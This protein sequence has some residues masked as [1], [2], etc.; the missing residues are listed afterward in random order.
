MLR[1]VGTRKFQAIA[2]SIS[3]A[4]GALEDC[5]SS[6]ESNSET[7]RTGCIADFQ[8]QRGSFYIAPTQP[9]E[10][11]THNSDY[12]ILY[13]DCDVGL[14]SGR[15]VICQNLLGNSSTTSTRASK[16]CPSNEPLLTGGRFPAPHITGNISKSIF[17]PYGSR[18]MSFKHFRA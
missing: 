6:F 7:A 5:T 8:P 10:V 17:I 4:L 9:S 15:A 12:E 18:S 3:L 11:L 13:E 2:I 16:E 14:R 1:L